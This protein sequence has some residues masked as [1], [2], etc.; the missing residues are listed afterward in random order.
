M[1][2]RHVDLVMTALTTL[3]EIQVLINV[4]MA[5]RYEKKRRD[6]REVVSAMMTSTRTTRVQLVVHQTCRPKSVGT[7]S[8]GNK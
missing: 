6:R 7:V 8:G 4:G 1:P 2:Q 5:G 3:P